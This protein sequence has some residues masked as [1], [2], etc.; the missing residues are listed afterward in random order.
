M[1]AD[2]SHGYTKECF[3]P[4]FTYS[5]LLVNLMSDTL[6]T[7]PSSLEKTSGDPLQRIID[8]FFILLAVFL[9]FSAF[10]NVAFG[11]NFR[12]YGIWSVEVPL[13]LLCGLVISLLHLRNPKQPEKYN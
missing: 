6:E 12:S 7:P 8:G 13:L 1:C 10:L 11:L 2:F 9:V 5:T 3:I 4:L